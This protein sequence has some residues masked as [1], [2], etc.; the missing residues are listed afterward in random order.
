M[1]LIILGIICFLLIVKL[2]PANSNLKSVSNNNLTPNSSNILRTGSLKIGTQAVNIELAENDQQWYQGLSNRDS[3]G[4]DSG[5]YFIFPDK[6]KLDFVM[7]NMRFPLDIIFINDDKILNIAENLA[8]EGSETKNIYSS[9]GE[10]NRVLEVNAGFCQ[11]HGI[12]GGD[13]ISDLKIN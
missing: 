9:N 7:R 4:A 13:S 5:M 10:A 3:L 8:P 6:N 1:P 11:M 12:K 2:P